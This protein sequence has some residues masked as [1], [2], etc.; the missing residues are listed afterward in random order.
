MIAY[1]VDA[2]DPGAFSG[3]TD[4]GTRAREMAEDFLMEGHATRARV[5]LARSALAV[6]GLNESYQRIGEGWT[7]IRTGRQ[8]SWTLLTARMASLWICGHRGGSKHGSKSGS[9]AAV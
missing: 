5:E 9:P 8:V 7:A 2:C 4:N 6:P 3:I 1:L